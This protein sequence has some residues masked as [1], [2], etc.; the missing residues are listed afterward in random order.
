MTIITLGKVNVFSRGKESSI[1]INPCT[2]FNLMR[3]G[4]AP[5][6]VLYKMS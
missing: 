2:L 1:L 4:F 6:I 5:I 3:H